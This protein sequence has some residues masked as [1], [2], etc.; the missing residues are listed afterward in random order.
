MKIDLLCG[1]RADE[2]VV[3]DRAVRSSRNL[4]KE[5]AT[6]IPISL[7]RL[8]LVPAL[9]L[10]STLV[11]AAGEHVTATAIGSVGEPGQAAQA[12]R[13]I[14][15]G[16]TDAMRFT[17]AAIETRQGETVRFAVKNSGR[18]KHELV[19]GTEQKL[20]EHAELMW[21][22]PEMEH[23]DPGMVTVAPGMTGELVWRFTHSGRVHFA[24]L[25]PGHYD[26]GMMGRVRVAGSSPASKPAGHSGHKH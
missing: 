2:P 24:C 9:L 11:V 15:I 3:A 5:R 6:S 20:K 16:M 13:T 12:T 19:L 1:R 25:Q 18:V 21:K 4:A 8:A 17:P 7:A 22:N 10:G 23:A 14:R 26:A